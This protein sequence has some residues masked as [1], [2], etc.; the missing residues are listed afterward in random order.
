MYV[1]VALNAPLRAGARAFTFA[2]PPARAEQVRPGLAGRVPFGRQ[3]TTGFVVGDADGLPPQ[4]R[5][6]AG[7][8]E[9]VPVLPPEL[10]ELARW[11]AAHYVCSIG[12]ALWARLPPP[13]AAAR[14]PRS[15]AVPDE[16]PPEA[17]PTAEPGEVAQLLDGAASA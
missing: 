1:D 14:R 7:I 2:V 10:V 11:M 5:P 8:D 4:V 16:A 3:T 15:A 17:P 13:A 6:L 12:A 9:R